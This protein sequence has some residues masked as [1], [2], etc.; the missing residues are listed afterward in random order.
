M[1]TYVRIVELSD[2]Q[3]HV[4]HEGRAMLRWPLIGVSRSRSGR[5]RRRG[6]RISERATSPDFASPLAGS[7]SQRDLAR[8]PVHNRESLIRL[9]AITCGIA[10]RDCPDHNRIQALH[11][12]SGR[13]GLTTLAGAASISRPSHAR[14]KCTCRR[15]CHGVGDRV[16]RFAVEGFW[17]L[18]ERVGVGGEGF[19]SGAGGAAAG[20]DGAEVVVGGRG[21]VKAFAGRLGSRGAACQ[22]QSLM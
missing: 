22:T 1:D 21:A 16:R 10:R 14:R 4:E 13:T 2:E 20:L 3:R 17:R 18:A 5:L 12:G 15:R 7:R 6:A 8:H 9:P 19:C 11:P